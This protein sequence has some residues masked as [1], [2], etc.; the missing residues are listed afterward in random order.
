[1]KTAWTQVSG[2]G[3][4]KF[5]DPSAPRTHVTYPTAGAY[6]LELSAT[7]GELTTTRKVTVTVK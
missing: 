2:P 6:V 7:D 4:A 5:E 3:A 1:M